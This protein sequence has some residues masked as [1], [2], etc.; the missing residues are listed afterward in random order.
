MQVTKLLKLLPL[1][2]LLMLIT[3]GAAMSSQSSE[4]ILDGFGGSG[5]H[6][7]ILTDNDTEWNGQ[8]YYALLM[9]RDRHP[10]QSYDVQIYNK[11][12]KPALT[13][14]LNLKSYPA[15]VLIKNHKTVST[16]TGPNNWTSIYKKLNHLFRLS[17]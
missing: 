9:M 10:A 5:Y 11:K 4:N 14:H 2:I 8:Y 13:D 17:S 1:F 6:T 12:E 15:L 16:I 3:G 7:I